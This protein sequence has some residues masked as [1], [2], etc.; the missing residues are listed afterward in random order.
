M[1]PVHAS[2]VVLEIRT[3][4]WQKVYMPRYSPTFWDMLSLSA[5]RFKSFKPAATKHHFING[6]QKNTVFGPDEENSSGEVN[7]PWVSDI[8]AGWFKKDA[9]FE[10]TAEAAAPDMFKDC[11]RPTGRYSGETKSCFQSLGHY[12]HVTCHLPTPTTIRGAT[13]LFKP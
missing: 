13:W 9:N 10:G 7:S 12:T 2:A 4:T 1:N 11:K 6:A 5:G 8:P 3:F